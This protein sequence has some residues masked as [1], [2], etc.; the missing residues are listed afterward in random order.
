MPRPFRGGGDYVLN[1]SADQTTFIEKGYGLGDNSLPVHYSIGVLNGTIKFE[2]STFLKANKKAMQPKKPPPTP[3]RNNP[4]NSMPAV[5]V[6]KVPTISTTPSQSSTRMRCAA[7][8]TKCLDEETPT[9]GGSAIPT[10][11]PKKRKTCS[12]CGKLAKLVKKIV[13]QLCLI[14]SASIYRT[15]GPSDCTPEHNP[16]TR[17]YCVVA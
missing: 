9:G 8:Q 11:S 13:G 7:M 15:L 2:H 14:A 3:I 6:G 4:K 10:P 1:G 16:W 5:T 17:G 12:E